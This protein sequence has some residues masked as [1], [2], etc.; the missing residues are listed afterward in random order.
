M[1]SLREALEFTGGQLFRGVLV[2]SSFEAQLVHEA[3]I[4]K[5]LFPDV[6]RATNG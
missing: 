4:L 5:I 2:N 6:P 1:W 3:R